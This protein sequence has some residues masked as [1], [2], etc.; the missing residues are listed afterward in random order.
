MTELNAATSSSSPELQNRIHHIRRQGPAKREGSGKASNADANTVGAS[1]AKL[2]GASNKRHAVLKERMSKVDGQN[3]SYGNSMK[4]LNELQ[5]AAGLENI[6]LSGISTFYDSANLP[7]DI[8][9][10]SKEASI[11]E[12]LIKEATAVFANQNTVSTDP[13]HKLAVNLGQLKES[14]SSEQVATKVDEILDEI[15]KLRDFVFSE[16]NMNTYV[17]WENRE[18]CP[19]NGGPTELEA[20]GRKSNHHNYS[21]TIKATANAYTCAEM[22]E[23]KMQELKTGLANCIQKSWVLIHQVKLV[24]DSHDNMKDVV[25][26]AS[27]VQTSVESI[28]KRSDYLLNQEVKALDRAGRN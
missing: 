16:E 4:R 18:S 1:L 13:L 17:V 12:R 8:K 25:V 7:R 27:K 6:L 20:V 23:Q 15:N 28:L 5:Q 22:D 10:D 19:V 14:T 21:N 2:A 3:F 24:G 9:P 11:C 26:E